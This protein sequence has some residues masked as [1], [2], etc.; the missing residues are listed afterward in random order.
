MLVPRAKQRD[1]VNMQHMS[2]PCLPRSPAATAMLCPRDQAGAAVSSFS[3]VHHDKQNA[4][5]LLDRL[6]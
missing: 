3:P 2:T 5:L 6:Q 1:A 4:T